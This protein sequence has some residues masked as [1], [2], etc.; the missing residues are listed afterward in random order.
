MRNDPRP[1]RQFCSLTSFLNCFAVPA[2]LVAPFWTFVNDNEEKRR[3]PEKLYKYDIPYENR[4]KKRVCHVLCALE[5]NSI[6]IQY[7]RKWCRSIKILF[8]FHVDVI[9]T[10]FPIIWL[11]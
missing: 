11:F 8:L 4:R 3:R 2:I 5:G 6:K 9:Y 10:S 1:D 7:V